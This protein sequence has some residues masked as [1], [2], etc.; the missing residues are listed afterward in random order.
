MGALSDW[1]GFFAA[2]VGASA[3]LAGLLFVGVSLNLA[4]ILS[5]VFLPL[6][7][8]L[9][10][11]LLGAVLV[12][13]SLLLM[14]GQTLGIVA[15]E[16]LVVGLATWLGGSLVELRGR[17]AVADSGRA[18]YFAN[19]VLLQLATLPYIVAAALLWA[20]APGGLYW[21]AAA[22]LLSTVKAVTDAWVLL[23]EIN[24]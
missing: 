23:V 21:L 16:A 8:L 7:A 6:R 4:K 15:A 20:G 24:R 2:Q 11:G 13:S 3:T 10:L 19:A 17:R 5:A 14:P 22:V 9:A 1:Q 18:V 12:L